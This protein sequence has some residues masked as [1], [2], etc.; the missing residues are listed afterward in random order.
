MAKEDTFLPGQ[1]PIGIFDEGGKFEPKQEFIDAARAKAL[2]EGKKYYG[3]A[4]NF[5][6][7]RDSVL[8][9]PDATINFLARGAEGTGELAAGIASL[10]MKGAKLATTTDPDK[11]TQILSE[12][13]FTKYMGAFRDKIPTK[14]LYESDISGIEDT[15][16]AFGDVA[17]YASPLPVVPAGV[18]A[19]GA[20]S[21]AV[22]AGRGIAQ[23]AD[24][25]VKSFTRGDSGFRA[26]AGPSE[27]F[28]KATKQNTPL[29]NALK[30]IGEERLSQ[31]TVS[32]AAEFIG[33]RYPNINKK[34]LKGNLYDKNIK[35]KAKDF[36]NN[37][38]KKNAFSALDEL[39]QDEFFKITADNR[40][41]SKDNF[42]NEEI[43]NYLASKNV[44]L[45]DSQVGKVV[46]EFV[47]NAHTKA[48]K[49]N[50]SKEFLEKTSTANPI[51]IALRQIGEKK[52]EKLTNPE[53][54][55]LLREDYNLNLYDSQI[56]IKKLN[57]VSYRGDQA[58]DKV[59]KVLSSIKNVEKYSFD[60]LLELPKV[61]KIMEQEGIS[62]QY[63][64]SIKG[65]MNIVQEVVPQL[66]LP[67]SKILE[68]FSK[69]DQKIINDF[70]SELQ[71]ITGFDKSSDLGINVTSPLNRFLNSALNQGA[72]KKEIIEQLNKIDKEALANVL[73]KNR[74]I[75]DELVKARLTGID[76]D[77]L[78]LSHMENV[79][80]NWRTSLDA[81]N[82]FLATKTANQ[83]IQVKL[84]K[85]LKK[86][87]EKVKTA[88]TEKEKQEALNEFNKIK[89]ELID[90]DL[91]S[92]IDGQKIGADIDFEKSL[93][94]FATPIEDE[95]F[96]PTMM[97]TG[98]S[99]KSKGGIVSI[100]EMIQ[101]ISLKYTS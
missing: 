16:E 29:N 63:F 15:E 35:F 47:K 22:P 10:A 75:K 57:T 55:K 1:L 77:D 38:L 64:K 8:N 91:V 90:N 45:S 37:D 101:P 24:D 81:N 25:I 83:K 94:K 69:K 54:T 42:I 61:K 79:A 28:L 2:E 34:T 43:K 62:K 60:E 84:D 30:E 86:N 92:I 95:L 87:F 3:D 4:T 20:K 76:L 26:S 11:I 13:S 99:E 33:E 96:F 36:L 27:L 71:K 23:L 48:I 70:N 100:E 40:G 46:E 66:R 39:G 73:V 52:I 53:L 32:E 80:D 68:K 12:P 89:Q 82:F 78:N 14:D 41:F 67:T 72:S 98:A 59:K 44:N 51:N 31:M 97:R 5:E 85:D 17:Y 19:A 7:F 50:A 18:L 74:K 49:K 65:E 88:K 6:I 58:K 93:Q 9:L 21:V 56:T